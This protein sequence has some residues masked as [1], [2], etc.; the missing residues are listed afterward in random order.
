MSQSTS[1]T[2]GKI[3]QALYFDGSND[4]VDVPASGSLTLGTSM[5]VSVWFNRRA[6]TTNQALVTSNKY[7]T[8][9][10]NGNWLLRVTNGSALAFASYDGHQM[11]SGKNLLLQ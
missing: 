7:Y 5:T 2:I 4:Y 11:K 9:G 8:A 6:T 3:G 10:F 1:P